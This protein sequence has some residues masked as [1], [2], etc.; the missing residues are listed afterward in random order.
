MSIAEAKAALARAYASGEA[1]KLDSVS[2]DGM[3]EIWI[4]GSTLFL[5]PVIPDDAPPEVEYA[6]LLRREASFTGQCDMCGAAFG[7]EPIE[8]FEASSL[9][10]GTFPHRGNCLATDENILPLLSAYYEKRAEASLNEALGAASKRT[11]E[12]IDKNIP[13]KIHVSPKGEM[14]KRF[15][16]YVDKKIA[17]AKGHCAHLESDPVQTWNI[18]M[19]DDTWRCDECTGLFSIVYRQRPFLDP[20]EDKSCDYCRRYSPNFLQ[21]TITKLDTFVL[22]GAACKRCAREF[23]V[24]DESAEAKT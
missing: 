2:P 24:G 16:G 14:N 9:S 11:Q 6:L 18:A 5:L 7:V 1:P 20:I 3:N 8:D 22:Y 19:W 10:A 12:K 13:N 23:G 17:A 21:Q 15:I 4:L